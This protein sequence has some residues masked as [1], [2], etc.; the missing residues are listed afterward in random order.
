MFFRIIILV[1]KSDANLITS[2][3]TFVL[4]VLLANNLSALSEGLLLI[5]LTLG[6][7]R[8]ASSSNAL[9]HLLGNFVSSRHEIIK[10]Q[11]FLPYKYVI[12]SLDSNFTA[13]FFEKSS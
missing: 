12:F 6:S 13:Y 10:L 7:S 2:L 8:S 9:I 5:Q 11:C 3:M 4:N 1:S